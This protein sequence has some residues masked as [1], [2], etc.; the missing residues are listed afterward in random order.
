LRIKQVIQSALAC[1]LA[2]G[3]ASN[4]SAQILAK[5]FNPAG[6][7]YFHEYGSADMSNYG[8]KDE[9]I[10][11]GVTLLEK[12][13]DGKYDIKIIDVRNNLIS[14]RGDGGEILLARSGTLDTTFIYIHPGMAIEVYSFWTGID[15]RH[16]FSILSSKGG[17]D[18]IVH[19]S[20]A[21]VGTCTELNLKPTRR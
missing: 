14:L 13:A 8:W 4:A 9:K 16:R 12:M 5:C 1:V 17:D 19:K 15:G 3:L 21:L 6:F 18:M 2:F 11:G 7:G 20:A 10:S